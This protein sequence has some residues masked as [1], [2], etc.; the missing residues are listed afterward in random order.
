MDDARPIDTA[1][2]D[3]RRIMIFDHQWYFARWREDAEF[4][5]FKSG[6]GW[7]IF[8]CDEDQYYSVASDEATHWMP[9]PEAP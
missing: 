6:P 7:Q 1:P 8:D 5:Q 4:G 9:S 2:R 3:G